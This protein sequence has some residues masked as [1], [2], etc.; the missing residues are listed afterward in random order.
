MNL[1][2]I[3]TNFSL[4]GANLDVTSTEFQ[5]D[6]P[7]VSLS[8]KTPEGHEISFFL[9]SPE[10]VQKLANQILSAVQNARIL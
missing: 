6:H 3:N 2:T 1:T 5:G 9:E 7:F 4:N 10:S 8:F